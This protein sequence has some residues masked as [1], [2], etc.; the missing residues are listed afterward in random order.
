MAWVSA[1]VL[2]GGLLTTATIT[3]VRA[4]DDLA[5]QKRSL[6]EITDALGKLTGL[7]EAAEVRR[8][9]MIELCDRGKVTD[10]VECAIARAQPAPPP[11]KPRGD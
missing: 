10:E 5:E 7:H 11:P 3:L 8:K 4:G 9:Q 1:I 2:L 6:P